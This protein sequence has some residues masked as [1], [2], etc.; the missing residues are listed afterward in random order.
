LL[1]GLLNVEMLIRVLSIYVAIHFDI[2]HLSEVFCSYSSVQGISSFLLCDVDYIA[3][4]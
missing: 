1:Q 3:C 4:L 2:F